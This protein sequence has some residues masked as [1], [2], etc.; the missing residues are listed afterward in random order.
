MFERF[1]KRVKLILDLAR[2]E[3][4][5]YGHNKIGT[6]HILLGIV[7]EG[8]GMGIAVLHYL[9][10]DAGTLKLEIEKSMRIG[11]PLLTI[12]EI[13]LSANAKRSLELSVKEA[14]YLGHAYIGSEHLLLGLV[15][16]DDSLAARVLAKFGITLHKIRRS[17]DD[18][19]A[20][21]EPKSWHQPV[22]SQQHKT[23]TPY[24]D[25]FGRD[26]TRFAREGK[27]DPVIGREMEIQRVTQILCRRKKNN[28]VL[29]G[30]A[31]VGKTAIVEG[32]A[33]EIEGKRVPE[34]LKNKRIVML[35]LPSIVAGTKYRGEFEQR[36]K[37]ILDE[38][39]SSKN[40]IIFID[41]L[42]TLVG[43]GGAE[44]AI[45]A[46]N[47]LKPA[48]SRGEI[49][50][51]GA[52]TL[53]EYRKYI[54]KDGALERRFQQI[55]VN[56]PT[57]QETIEILKGLRKKYEEHHHLRI[58]DDA[59]VEA[60]RL[61]DRYITGRFLPDKA[62]DLIDEAGSRQRLKLSSPPEKIEWLAKE[63]Q[64]I[65]VRKE[66]VMKTQDF[67]KAA[68]LRDTERELKNE[69]DNLRV[70]WE[71]LIPEEERLITKRNIAEV[72]S[73]WTGIPVV[74][75]CKE[76][77]ER[78]LGMEKSLR[79][80]VV[81]QEEAISAIARAVRRT[82]AG[83]RDTGR[84]I[85]SFLF[86]GPTGVGKTLLA[87]ALAEF[88]FGDEQAII[89][90]DM[91][92]YMEKFSVSRLIGAPPGYVGYEEGGQLTEQV[93]RRP[94]CVV[95]LDEVEKAHQEVFNL[96]L[97][98]L[99]EGRLTDSFGRSVSFRNAILI[100]TS[101]IGT[102]FTKNS[103]LMGFASVENAEL[104]YESLK[105]KI[106]GRVKKIFRSEFLNRLD[107]TIVFQPLSNK[108]L[109]QIVDLELTKV[110]ERLKEQN[111]SIIVSQKA[112]QF[113]ME[114]GTNPQFGARP[115]RRI[116][117]RYL[118]D[119]LS[120]DILRG[121]FPEKAIIMI[122]CKNNALCFKVLKKGEIVEKT[123]CRVPVGSS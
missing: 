63:A 121:V 7:E 75:L 90:V 39:K 54:E 94:Y 107:E 102:D 48:L 115:L 62:I 21:T 56:A 101:N 20:E 55:I 42:H 80:V 24:L 86:L 53:N 46:S 38:I 6:E 52:T 92:E 93:R 81:G 37:S 117:S 34:I 105:E 104:A 14:Q 76:E 40:I 51:I 113:L 10:V 28:P 44:G 36:I 118:E 69:L 43:A 85:G 71:Q 25:S 68:F 123:S 99:E 110:I 97:Q 2:K 114:K 60:V 122:D 47:I 70:N 50:C 18:L 9:G 22:G 45:D 27:L 58:S 26:L 109:L 111:L 57:G 19:L 88:L 59:I 112:K 66:E 30:E 15:A 120:E 89:Q 116:I 77:K 67:Q 100:M 82:R 64:K 11:I 32:F 16:E 72:V 12:G 4:I 87:R 17:I 91:S 106:L 5:K 49:Q 13:P 78:L 41:E 3:A 31:G 119:K 98:V 73:Q 83:L 8:Q 84:P 95:L 96:L 35:D 65:T 29:L 1:T 74:E 79:E 61:S 108:E 23:K 33:Q 103:S